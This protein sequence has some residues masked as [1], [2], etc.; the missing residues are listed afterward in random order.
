V[1][2][3]NLLTSSA[4]TWTASAIFSPT[5]SASSMFSVYPNGRGISSGPA[6]P[7]RSSEPQKGECMP[8]TQRC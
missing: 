1:A 7:A 5:S 4:G 3:T 6:S 2:C 8:L